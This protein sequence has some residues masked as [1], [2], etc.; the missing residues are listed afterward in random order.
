M[1]TEMRDIGVEDGTTME[2]YLALP[3][4]PNGKAILV[5]QEIFGV[6]PHIRSVTD[7]Y[8]RE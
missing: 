8:A 3:D 6:N 2:T 5:I 1:R 4:A 7:R